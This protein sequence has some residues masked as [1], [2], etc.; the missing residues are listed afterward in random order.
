MGDDVI[1]IIFYGGA[2]LRQK[3]AFL[4]VT[5]FFPIFVAMFKKS[6]IPFFQNTQ[7]ID[8]KWVNLGILTLW[9]SLLFRSDQSIGEI[10]L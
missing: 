9:Y 7:V 4:R 5:S 3:M 6:M 8:T 2:N 1:A 10:F